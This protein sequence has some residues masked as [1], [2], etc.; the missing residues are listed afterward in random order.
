MLFLLTLFACA[1]T[2]YDACLAGIEIACAC[3]NVSCD[4]TP[5]GCCYSDEEAEQACEEY[6]MRYCD[7]DGGMYDATLCGYAEGNQDPEVLEYM[8][9]TQ[10]VYAEECD[11]EP[12]AEECPA[13]E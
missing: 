4:G 6:D 2:T 10:K 8:N 5:E 9:C 11:Q 1:E 7:P 13:P 3:E 12:V